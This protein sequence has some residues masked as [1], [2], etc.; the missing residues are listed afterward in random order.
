MGGARARNGIA[1]AQPHPSAYAPAYASAPGHLP[2]KSNP[3]QTQLAILILAAAAVSSDDLIW[4]GILAGGCDALIR[5]EAL[6]D[7]FSPQHVLL[8]SERSP[9]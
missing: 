7:F 9:K 5:C 2:R 4:H 8:G 6:E 1:P 3:F